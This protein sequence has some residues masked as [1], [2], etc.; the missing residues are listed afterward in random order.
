M[1]IQKERHRQTDR[2]TKIE[3]KRKRER[4][5][6]Q[7]RETVMC[8]VVLTLVGPHERIALSKEREIP[9]GYGFVMAP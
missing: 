3:C 1:R 8:R 4:K 9:M 5:R 2:Q 7:D 6:E